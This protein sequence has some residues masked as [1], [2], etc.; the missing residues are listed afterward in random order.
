MLKLSKY[1]VALMIASQ[2]SGCVTAVVG[3]A[4]AGASI[5]TDRRTSGIVVEDQNVEIKA[6]YKI[7][8]NLGKETRISVTSF[9]R[10]I[11][12]T[13]EAPTADIKA[14]AATLI[15]TIPNIRSIA[16]EVSVMPKA[17]I[18][19]RS[20]DT[21]IT[22]KV[23]GNFVAERSALVNHVKV[24]TERSVVYLMGLVTTA[25]AAE[26]VEVARTT[27]GVTKVVKLFEYL[28]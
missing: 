12:L 25:E 11:L 4:A 13:G 28:P 19:E 18:K 8:K 24:V 1:L 22:S 26:A 2:L 7:E 16:N 5:A 3:G 10:N 27:S 17:S 9:N 23:K 20:N 14:R 15:K 6:Q 21:Y